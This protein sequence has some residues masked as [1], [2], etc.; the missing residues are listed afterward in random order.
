MAAG[1]LS[2]WRVDLEPLEAWLERHA[3]WGAAV[4]VL[5]L[6]GSVVIAPL[7]SLPL[8][9]VAASLYGVWITG[10]LSAIGW[11]LGALVA[12]RIARFGRHFVER[13]ASLEAVDRL[14][15]KIPPDVGFS[16]IVIL[17]IILPTDV[18]SFALGF[19]KALQFRL[20]AAGALIGI[21]P[22]SFVWAYAGGHLSA[23]RF[24]EFAVVGVGM[25]LAVLL[26]RRLFYRFRR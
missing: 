8:V 5:V 6:A 18:A 3:G 15:R 19:L 7:V 20:F 23:G 9:P 2:A 11:W 24:L 12:F 16:G 21:L 4:Y 1:V 22:F 26:L 14:E 25:A 10:L 17:L 13:L